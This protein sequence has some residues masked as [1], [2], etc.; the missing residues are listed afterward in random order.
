MIFVS[1]CNGEANSE[2]S[3]SGG[4][5]Y[6]LKLGSALAEDDPIYQGLVDFSESVKEKTDGDVNIEIFG[7]GSLGNDNDIIEQAKSGTNVAVLVDAGRLADMVPEIG[8]LSAPY[9]VDNFDEANK[10][11]QS[12]LFSGWSEQLAAEQNLQVLSF[13]WYQGERHLLTNKEITAP[14]DLK[15]LNIRTIDAPVALSTMEALGL[16]P[17]G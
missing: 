8:V 9:I 12:D 10:V 13:N 14:E 1:A 6:T 11:V 17:S 3:S 7:N 16:S 2:D 15:G 4:G 5:E